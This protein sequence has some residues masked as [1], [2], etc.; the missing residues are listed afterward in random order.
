MNNRILFIALAAIVLCSCGMRGAMETTYVP[1]MDTIIISDSIALIRTKM[2]QYTCE[3]G[4]VRTFYD[5]HGLL[6]KS[7]SELWDH[8]IYCVE[9]SD[10]EGNKFRQVYPHWSEATLML[11]EGLPDNEGYFH[12]YYFLPSPDGKNL[13]VVTRDY[14]C[15]RGGEGDCNLQMID[16]ETLE[17]AYICGFVT[18]TVLKEGFVVEQGRVINA[19]TATCVADQLYYSHEEYINWSGEV[20]RV[21]KI[22]WGY[23]KNELYAKLL[24][25][26]RNQSGIINGFYGPYED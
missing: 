16:C 25:I 15:G 18:I 10:F 24:A 7:D 22:E 23:H 3:N 8:Y 13:F 2:H 20:T 5:V 9:E 17:V 19:E 4:L 26:Y 6:L 21:S 14:G 1:E 11:K 12:P